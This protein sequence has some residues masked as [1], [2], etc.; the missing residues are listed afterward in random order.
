MPEIKCVETE[1]MWCMSGKD[2]RP[3]Y[4]EM[5]IVHIIL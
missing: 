3:T 1:R 2:Q 5:D 4:G